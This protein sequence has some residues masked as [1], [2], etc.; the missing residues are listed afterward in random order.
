MVRAELGTPILW[1]A[2]GGG[3]GGEG[4]VLNTVGWVMDLWH[5]HTLHLTA[6]SP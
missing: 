4:L 2:L 6:P 1:R 3:L 5:L